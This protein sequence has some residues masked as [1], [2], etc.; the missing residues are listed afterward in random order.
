M[1]DKTNIEHKGIVKEIN[2]D[3]IIVKVE[4]EAT[5]SACRAK[6]FCG[7]DTNEKIVEINKWTGEYNIGDQVKIIMKQA[8]GYKAVVYGYIAPF[9][10]LFLSIIVLI[11]IGMNEGIAG[12]ISLALLVPYYYTLYFFRDSLKKQFTFSIKKNYFN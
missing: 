8:L 9:F 10:V 5:C 1:S 11:S 4:P 7:A 6:T 2:N 3:S 12:L